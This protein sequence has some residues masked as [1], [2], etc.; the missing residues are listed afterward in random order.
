M[1]KIKFF[2]FFLVLFLSACSKKDDIVSTKTP[3]E[4]ITNGKWYISAFT[5]SVPVD[6][7]GNGILITNLLTSMSACEKDN[8]LVFKSNLEVLFN[9]GLTK[10]SP[11]DPQEDT[12]DWK[13][14][15]GEK[16]IE[17]S[18]EPYTIVEL[19]ASALVIKEKNSQ[20]TGG[21]RHVNTISFRH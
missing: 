11:N 6:L 2:S 7:N 1:K 10:C 15:N 19:T 16:E 20:V 3:M 13:F 12:E 17:M 14:L 21:V 9:E 5:S 8:Y 4:F 18:G